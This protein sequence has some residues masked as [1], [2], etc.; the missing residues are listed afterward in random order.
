MAALAIS[1]IVKV[2]GSEPRTATAI[3]ADFVAFEREFSK[4]ITSL[5]DNVFLTDLLWLAWHS[6]KRTNATGLEFE[7][8]VETVETVETTDQDELVPLESRASTGS[9]AS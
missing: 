9:S 1:M 8:W 3:P 6:E 5:Q 7:A 4:S 2:A